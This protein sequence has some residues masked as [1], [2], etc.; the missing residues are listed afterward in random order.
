MRPRQSLEE[1]KRAQGEPRG[2]HCRGLPERGSR[3]TGAE[4]S[5]GGRRGGRRRQDGPSEG[6]AAEGRE[7][8]GAAMGC[9]GGSMTTV[10][11]R[12]A[13]PSAV[14]IVL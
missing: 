2:G 7:Q 8:H 5:L 11:P 9:V 3:D 12:G 13:C 10:M 1:A 14:S 4:T 6:A